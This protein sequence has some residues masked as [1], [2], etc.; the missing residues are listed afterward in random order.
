MPLPLEQEQEFGKQALRTLGGADK[1]KNILGLQDTDI[2]QAQR[3]LDLG[4]GP[5]MGFAEDIKKK[6]PEKEVIS[7]DLALAD[8]EQRK[9]WNTPKDLPGVA[10]LF[11]NLPF[12]DN[13]FDLAVSSCA[14]PLWVPKKDIEH[15]R[16]GIVEILRVLK[17]GKKALLGP[18]IGPWKEREVAPHFSGFQKTR[19]LLQRVLCEEA[20]P[21]PIEWERR[22]LRQPQET[23]KEYFRGLMN[24]VLHPP[25]NLPTPNEWSSEATAEQKERWRIPDPADIKAMFDSIPGNYRYMMRGNLCILEKLAD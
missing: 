6:H 25:Q 4:S 12:A 19:S 15:I 24:R 14:F 7:V 1:Y 13:S 18:F 17:P 5:T 2:T 8:D 11:T 16:K 22:Q 23:V 21:D 9:L 20:N 3:I 10:A